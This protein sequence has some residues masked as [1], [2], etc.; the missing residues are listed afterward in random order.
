MREPPNRTPPRQYGPV[1]LIDGTVVDSG[2]E[3]WRAECEARAVLAMPSKIKRQDY[4]NGYTDISGRKHRGVRE[5][6][7]PVALA[8]LQAL[9]MKIWQARQVAP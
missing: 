2:S 1:T 9:V 6:R 7:G 3:A 8:E 5:Q 4:L